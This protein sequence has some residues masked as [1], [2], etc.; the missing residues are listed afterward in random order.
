MLCACSSAQFSKQNYQKTRLNDNL[1]QSGVKCA[2]MFTDLLLAGSP[3]AQG[4]YEVSGGRRT[5]ELMESPPPLLL[6][7]P[8]LFSPHLSRRSAKKKECRDGRLKSDL[9]HQ[10][11]KFS[12]VKG[13][14]SRWLSVPPCSRSAGGGLE[15]SCCAGRRVRDVT[16][17]AGAHTGHTMYTI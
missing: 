10:S 13:A 15:E 7:L 2:V 6:L 12:A 8:R 1:T 3:N 9:V 16:K 14:P 4:R 11:K 17:G 5:S